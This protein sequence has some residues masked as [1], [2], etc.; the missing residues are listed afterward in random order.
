MLTG[1]ILTARDAAHK[2]MHE[3]LRDGKRIP[4]E[5]ANTLI[6]YCGPSPVSTGKS[7]GAIGP[8]TSARMDFY[9]EELIANGLRMTMGKGNRSL[10]VEEMIRN[11]GSVYLVT[12]GGAAAYLSKRVVSCETFLW[13][14]MGAEAIYKLEVLDF[15]AYIAIF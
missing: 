7:C 1:T 3:I 10:K 2:R 13:Q 6:F 4:F 15:P 12:V 9:M 5:L 11:S 8:T 14:D